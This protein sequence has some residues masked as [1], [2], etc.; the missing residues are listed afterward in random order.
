MI[1]TERL[2][3]R[4]PKPEDAEWMFESVSDPNVQKWLPSPPHPYTFEHAQEWL[5]RDNPNR[6]VVIMQG[7]SIGMV[8]FSGTADKL[9]LGYWLE[10]PHWG[11]GFMFEAAHASVDW[12]F[13]QGYS[14]LKSGYILGNEGSKSI[15]EK[16]GFEDRDIVKKRSEFFNDVVPVQEM[17]LSAQNFKSKT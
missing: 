8:T 9:D 4:P 10:P 3:L 13:A 17:Y 7:K 1:A 2:F 16:L 14:D 15:L 6:F 5:S 11:Q 12:Y